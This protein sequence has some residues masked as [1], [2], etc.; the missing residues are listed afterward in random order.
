MKCFFFLLML[1]FSVLAQD[2]GTVRMGVNDFNFNNFIE[3][4]GKNIEDRRWYFDT[5][6]GEGGVNVLTEVMNADK[7]D[8][9]EIEKHLYIQKE[10][11]HLLEADWQNAW[12]AL[13]R[14]KQDIASIE[15]WMANSAGFSVA[16][17]EWAGWAAAVPGVGMSGG[18][19]PS[20]MVPEW[21]EVLPEVPKLSGQPRGYYFRGL[22]ALQESNYNM[23]FSLLDKKDE[24]F[25]K[26]AFDENNE[27]YA[28]FVLERVEPYMEQSQELSR[29]YLDSM[30]G[31]DSDLWWLDDGYY[32][33][34]MKNLY[35]QSHKLYLCALDNFGRVEGQ[36]I[37]ERFGGPQGRVHQ[38]M[39]VNRIGSWYEEQSWETF[40]NLTGAYDLVY[41]SEKPS[42]IYALYELQTAPKAVRNS[43]V[44]FFKKIVDKERTLESDLYYKAL[45]GL[46]N[47]DV[48]LSDAEEDA[49][50]KAREKYIVIFPD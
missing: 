5:V 8:L 20:V 37:E 15:W 11:G 28:A 42:V 39:L 40:Q 4:T 26:G 27:E 18:E 3:S 21:V 6:F 49:L 35:L 45:L 9:F 32:I 1:P 50:Y 31:K 29:T 30:R 25:Y 34:G 46:R 36:V 14:Q 16:A 41:D 43:T 10:T 23:A 13:I 12:S 48:S 19:V 44:E 24:G 17:P 2:W 22:R 47:F 7:S 33:G 38:D